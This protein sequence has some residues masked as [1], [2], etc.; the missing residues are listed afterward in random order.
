MV[1]SSART[2]EPAIVKLDES[3]LLV[4]LRDTMDPVDHDDDWDARVSAVIDEILDSFDE[5][6]SRDEVS[7]WV[8][9]HP[10]VLGSRCSRLDPSRLCEGRS[11][12]LECA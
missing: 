6:Q 8:F 9:E 1:S 11:S 12:R 2:S 3:K 5:F 10:K 7:A 4:P